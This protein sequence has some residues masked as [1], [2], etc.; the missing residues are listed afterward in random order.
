MFVCNCSNF[1]KN[2]GSGGATISLIYFSG[3]FINVT[4]SNQSGPVVRVSNRIIFINNEVIMHNYIHMYKY[5]YIYNFYGHAL[6]T[7]MI[8]V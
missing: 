1:D 3:N 8:V 2:F 4:F 7:R 5:W 6:G